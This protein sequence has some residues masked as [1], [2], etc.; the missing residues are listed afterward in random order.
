LIPPPTEFTPIDRKVVEFVD[1]VAGIGFRVIELEEGEVVPQHH[2]D[3]YDHAT[4]IGSGKARLWINGQY[5]AD[6]KKGRAV[7]I[8]AKD[9][10]MWQA[11]EPGTL[12]ACISNAEMA[13]QMTKG[14]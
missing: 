12:I 11:L 9:E 7:C 3:D 1:V 5:V 8:H 14:V 13:E 10:H 2:H 6:L 4:F